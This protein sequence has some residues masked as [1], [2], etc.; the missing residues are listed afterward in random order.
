[1][2]GNAGIRGYIIQTIICMLDA[3]EADNEWLTVTLEP[4]DESEKVDIRWLYPNNIKKVTQVKSSQNIIRY[5]EAEKWCNDLESK[6]PDASE[7]ELLLIGSGDKRLHKREDIGK[8]KIGEFRT[9][10]IQ[11]L[12]D[13]ASTKIDAFYERKGKDKIS[14]KVRELIVHA[15]NS[16]FGTCSIVGH[17]VSKD[18]FDKKLLEWIGD[19][20]KQIEINP[21]ASLAPPI[22]GKNIPLNQ[23][24]T[25]KILGLIGWS[26]F[27]ENYTVEKFNERTS[28][29]DIHSID[30]EC[31]MESNLKENTS[32]FVMVSAIHDFKYPNTSKREIEKY[33]N[34]TEVVFQDYKNKK[35]IPIKKFEKTNYFSLLFWLTTD[36]N[37]VTHDFVHSTKDNYKSALLNDELN[38]L[39]IDNKSASFLISSI[40]TANNY[41]SDVPVKYL[42]PITEENQS[43]DKIGQRG[44][45]LPVQYINSS[46]IPIAKEDKSKISFLLFCSDPYSPD[47]LKKLIWLAVKLT[48]GFGNEYLLY[49][50]DY[51]KDKDMNEAL[52]IIR[53]FNE[54]ILGDKIK[55]YRYNSID[56]NELD[57]IPETKRIN[58]KNEVYEESK[59]ELVVNTKHFNDALR[60]ILPYGDILKPLL[61]TD[62]INPGDMKVFLAKKGIFMKKSNRANLIGL[63]SSLLFSPDELYDFKSLIDVKGGN[64]H[65]TNEHFKIK[66]NDSLVNVFGKI[67][68]NFDNLT[69]TINAK[70]VDSG[71]GFVQSTTNKEEFILNL[72]TEIKD[73]NDSLLVNTRW[74]RVDIVVKKDN[75]RLVVATLNTVTKEDKLIANKA[76]RIL[77]NELE[78]IG[79]VEEKEIKVMF[80]SFASNLDRVNFLLSFTNISSSSILEEADIKSIKFKFDENIEIPELYKDKA[81]K[82][83]VIN[84]DGNGLS[85]LVE[86]SAEDAKGSILLEEIRIQYKFKYRNI[87]SGIYKVSYN[88]SGAFKNVPEINGVFNTEPYL[89]KTKS[90]K[91]LNDI[92][93]L[94]MV[95]SREVERLKIEKLK[96]FDII[97]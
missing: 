1:M 68:P 27:G 78:Q 36:N 44:L 82:D 58:T 23:R 83:L 87:R 77:H 40:I 38:Y 79:F 2:S 10:N 63:M 72:T 45:R 50:P 22:E 35:I 66:Q 92:N 42:Y 49:F 85:T 20:E 84:F 28:E 94:K 70:I 33:L 13:Q 51:Q 88:F 93:K 21:Y 54:D 52:R 71:K 69:D 46:V 7:F 65:T 15:M 24:I 12:I 53:S 95:L 39:F 30:F 32:D 19:I 43:P 16:Y 31:D 80:N 90:I 9:L 74:G 73:P 25:K 86:L 56:L 59:D 34:D 67:K 5:K 62:A 4:L 48:S 97:E 41:R 61:K 11:T 29:T 60:N 91:A 37:E 96:L 75:D 89:N 76:L 6:S 17:E 57:L 3:L 55:I 8:V 26:Q 81:D 18:D 47:A 64:V 14:P